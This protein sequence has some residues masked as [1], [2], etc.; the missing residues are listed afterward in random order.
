M[1]KKVIKRKTNNIEA[2]ALILTVN[3]KEHHLSILEARRLKQSL[4]SIFGYYTNPYVS[5]PFSST[6]AGTATNT[7]TAHGLTTTD[8]ITSI[9][10]DPTIA[11]INVDN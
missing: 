4:D 6:L 5:I 7:L 9:N 3:G 1:A 8:T 2:T 11:K 10:L